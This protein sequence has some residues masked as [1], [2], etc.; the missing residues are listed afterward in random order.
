[1]AIKY[2]KQCSIELND[3]NSDLQSKYCNECEDDIYEDDMYED[4]DE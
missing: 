1:M 3:E 2:C 4:F